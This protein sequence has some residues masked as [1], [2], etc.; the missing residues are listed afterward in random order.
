MSKQVDHD[1]IAI[2]ILEK[3]IAKNFSFPV[4]YKCVEEDGSITNTYT[5]RSENIIKEVTQILKEYI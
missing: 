4:T 2:E 5:E 1:F 3:V